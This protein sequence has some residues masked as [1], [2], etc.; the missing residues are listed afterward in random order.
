MG[1]PRVIFVNRVYWPSTEATAQ[2]L[3]DLA[4]GLAARGWTVH[5][6]AAGDETATQPGVTI[7]RTGTPVHHSGLLSR[8]KSYRRFLAA[9]RERL[10]QL[11]QPGD[12]VV[13]MTDP[14]MLGTVVAETMADRGVA[15]V[16]WIQD[17]YPEIA[18]VHFG[19]AAGWLLGGLRRRRDRAWASSAACVTLGADMAQAVTAM[20]VPASR[21]SV[22]PNW[23][24][25][26]LDELPP[27]VAVVSCRKQWKAGSRF[28]VAYSGNLGRVHEF[29]TILNAAEQLQADPR[30]AFRFIGRGAQWANL[31]A[32]G[33]ERGLANV[34]LQPAV[35]RAELAGVLGAADAHLVTLQPAYGRLVYPSKLAG[36]LAAGRPAVFVGPPSGDIARL[37]HAQECGAAFAPGAA[38]ELAATLRQWAA[39]PE[40][41]REFGRNA[42]RLYEE[43]FTATGALAQWDALLHRVART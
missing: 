11:A 26:E 14:P 17:I 35:P 34:E 3:T 9:A 40:R 31:L 37:L 36:I 33:R 8:T 6:I 27:A 29:A 42:R 1:E 4:G 43:K 15:V 20:G 13:A 25:R 16:Q 12:I 21:V 18:A 10:R 32:A 30:I 39:D 24:P 41:A 22:L 2:L 7:H 5:V 38:G 28:V 19:R 23:A